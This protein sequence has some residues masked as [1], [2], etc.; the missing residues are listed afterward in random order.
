MVC[1]SEWSTDRKY[2]TDRK[3]NLNSQIGKSW[4]TFKLDFPGRL[5]WAGF[6]I[7]AMPFT[8]SLPRISLSLSD[9]V[10]LVVKGVKLVWN[11]RICAKSQYRTWLHFELTAPNTFSQKE[12]SHNKSRFCLEMTKIMPDYVKS[13]ATF[14]CEA[15]LGCC[16]NR[17]ELSKILPGV[18]TSKR[19]WS[20]Q[21]KSVSLFVWQFDQSTR[22]R[23]PMK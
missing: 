22:E 11:G 18:Q 3:Y 23:L 9:F 6:A 13:T 19:M 20:T 4:L 2:K 8:S 16:V 5:C 1:Y 17:Q 10:N 21:G 15:W 12:K 7:L 14:I